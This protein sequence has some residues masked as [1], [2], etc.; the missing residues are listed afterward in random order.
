MKK[1]TIAFIIIIIVLMISAC[2]TTSKSKTDII[3]DI[4]SNLHETETVKSITIEKRDTDKAAK[5]DI[6]WCSVTTNDT[7]VERT[8]HYIV[9]YRLY[10][11]GGWILAD[12]QTDSSKQIS[13]RPIAGVDEVTVRNSLLG[14][15]LNI[16]GDTWDITQDSIYSVGVL[17]NNTD[18][19]AQTDKVIIELK[20]FADT[21]VAEGD[22]EAY[23]IFDNNGW[24]LSHVVQ[25]Q[26]FISEFRTGLG[27]SFNEKD[28]LSA[29][30]S[31]QMPY[32]K[33]NY[34]QFIT[35]NLDEIID[36]KVDSQTTENRGLYYI[37]NCNYILEKK[38]VSFSVNAKLIFS[39]DPNGGWAISSIDY[40]PRAISLNLL[41]DWVGTYT[42]NQGDTKLILE[43]KQQA[44]D[45]AI[46]AVFNFSALPTNPSV[47]SGSF[48]M[49]GGIDLENLFVVLEAT[50]W[51]EQPKN[52]RTIGLEG[53]LYVD[54]NYIQGNKPYKFKVTK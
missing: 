3:K 7:S 24:K 5:E 39:Y 27:P 29:L 54:D 49:V 23:Y 52:Y 13:A 42:A 33:G 41:G 25:G 4:Q 12:I 11:D 51:I 6:V 28:Y 17:S 44:A 53:I 35:S 47:P 14:K 37:V 43:I 36:F 50:E 18:L 1:V 26:N 20:L 45:G 16:N 9:K 40:S 22:L 2:S 19:K 15:T 21:M 46:S 8:R 38:A 48:K 34:Q 30:I 32:S 31:K 10:T